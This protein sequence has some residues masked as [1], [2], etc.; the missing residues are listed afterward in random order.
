MWESISIVFALINEYCPVKIR[1]QFAFLYTQ[2]NRS[3][4]NCAVESA[5][6]GFITNTAKAC[7]KNVVRS[8][9]QLAVAS[10]HVRDRICV[11]TCVPISNLA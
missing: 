6:F 8:I 5:I 7:D 9:A 10:G 1:F 4:V 3:T 11:R 2:P